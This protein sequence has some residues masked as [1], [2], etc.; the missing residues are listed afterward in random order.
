M[1]LQLMKMESDELGGQTAFETAEGLLKAS[2]AEEDDDG[3]A[4]DWR[5][6][7][8]SF[9]FGGSHMLAGTHFICSLFKCF[10]LKLL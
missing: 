5:K 6:G 1:I 9:T 7:S 4:L 2:A 3:D 10:S 8:F